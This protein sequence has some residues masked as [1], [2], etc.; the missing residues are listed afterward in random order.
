MAVIS[1]I[2]LIISGLADLIVDLIEYLT[3]RK[4]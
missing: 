3:E 1:L 4:K 2:A